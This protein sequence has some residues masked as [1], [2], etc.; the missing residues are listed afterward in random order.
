MLGLKLNHVSKRGQWTC[1]NG[2]LTTYVKL[3][4]ANAPGTFCGPPLCVTDP[5]MH[6][7]TCVTHAPRCMPGSLISAFLWSRW[8][9]K[10][11][12][13]PLLDIIPVQV[14]LDISRG[15]WKSLGSRK[16]PEL[17]DSSDRIESIKTTSMEDWR[18]RIQMMP[19]HRLILIYDYHIMALY[20]R[21]VWSHGF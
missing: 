4:V 18:I 8:R 3:R 9:G 20:Q 17:L 1:P 12:W 10:R 5:D 2:P 6:H 11:S 19:K 14:T 21:T 15:Q 7:G 16:Y 13:H